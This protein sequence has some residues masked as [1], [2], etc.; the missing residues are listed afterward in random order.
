MIFNLKL[1][2]HF[3]KVFLIINIFLI[4]DSLFQ[5]IFG[6]NIF[7]MIVQDESRISS[8]FGEELILGSFICKI[9][10]FCF[11]IL[12]TD[13]V[14]NNLKFLI[15]LVIVLNLIVILISGE[16]SALFLYLL[17]SLYLFVFIKVSFKLKLIISFFG[18][19]SLSLIIFNN[20]NVYDR[21]IDKTIFELIG[22]NSFTKN[23]FNENQIILKDFNEDKCLKSENLNLKECLSDDKFYFF[24]S[25]HENYF[26]TSLNIFKDN[27]LFGA[28]PKSFRKL[29][30]EDLYG[31]NRWSCSSHP[32]NYYIQLLAEVG[33][34]GLSFLFVGYILFFVTLVRVLNNQGLETK[35]KNFLYCFYWCFNN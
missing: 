24:S 30:G 3:L 13:N 34:I 10:P 21:I 5:F 17:L 12:F 6:S 32:H 19:I 35:Q 1:E 18:I 33:L 9:T 11:A 25:T 20:Q 31:I 2:E 28:G 7:G 4:I 29:C 27:L 15:Y 8:I 14:K 26:K 22:K 23:Y 16:R